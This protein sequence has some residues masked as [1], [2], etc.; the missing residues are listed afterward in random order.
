M[1]SSD[2]IRLGALGTLLAG[3]AWTA[4]GVIELVTTSGQSPEVLGFASLTEVMH[5]VAL[6]GALVGIL[7][8]HARKVAGYG[9][10]GRT[11]SLAAFGGTAL[12]LVGLLLTFL[13]RA[14]VGNGVYGLAFLDWVLGLGLWGTLVGFAFLGTAALRSGTLPPWCGLLLVAFLPLAIVLGD[15]G[16]GIVLGLSWMALGYV[17][18]R[19]RDVSA[20][21][22]TR[23]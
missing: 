13:V 18:M 10:L 5:V 4:S 9:R 15:Y 1:S 2:L 6:V 8:L 22:R 20:W 12:L 11:G 23:R 7:E 21:L 17:L 16:G 3:V 19:Q 14:L